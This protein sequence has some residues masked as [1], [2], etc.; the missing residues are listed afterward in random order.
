MTA[1]L[2]SRYSALVEVSI[3][4]HINFSAHWFWGFTYQ[5]WY[6]HRYKLVGQLWP[7]NSHMQC[8]YQWNTSSW[9]TV[10]T[11]QAR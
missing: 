9:D 4:P 10:C 8:L 5:V 11:G 3:C 6:V 2:D 1:K 7:R